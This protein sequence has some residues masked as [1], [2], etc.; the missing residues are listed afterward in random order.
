MVVL[1]ASAKP[2]RFSY[3][4]VTLLKQYGHRIIP[5]HPKLMTVADIPVHPNVGM[6]VCGVPMFE[7][8]PVDAV[9]RASKSLVQSGKADGL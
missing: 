2:Q 5:V 3:K 7:V 1:G 9:T 8:P 4:A 6:G